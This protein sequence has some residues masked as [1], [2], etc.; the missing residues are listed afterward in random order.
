[1]TPQELADACNNSIAAFKDGRFHGEFPTV[2]LTTPRDKCP[3]GRS[4]RL[5]GRHGPSGQIANCQQRGDRWIVVAYYNANDVL[6]ELSSELGIDMSA[7]QPP[8]A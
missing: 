2:C 6:K 8:A 7:P 4:V 3:T 1:M 5:F